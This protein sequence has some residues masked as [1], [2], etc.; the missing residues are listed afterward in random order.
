MLLIFKDLKKV[1][2]FFPSLPGLSKRLSAKTRIEIG[3]S[4]GKGLDYPVESDAD[5][6]EE[7]LRPDND[8]H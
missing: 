1:L 6:G 4:R 3:Q 5:L 7:S 8:N 2:S